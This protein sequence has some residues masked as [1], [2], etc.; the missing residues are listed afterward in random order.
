MQ[1]AAYVPEYVAVHE[2]PKHRRGEDGLGP[3][4]SDLVDPLNSDLKDYFR[5]KICETLVEKGH[6][7]VAAPDTTSMVPEAITKLLSEKHDLLTCSR[8]LA[9]A[10]YNTQSGSNNAGLLIAL[11]GRI[12]DAPA[13]AVLKLERLQGVRVVSETT[14]SGQRHFNMSHLRDLMLNE[15][16]RVFKAGVFTLGARGAVEGVVSDEQRGSRQEEVATF[17]LN[18]FLGCELRVSPKAATKAFFNTAVDWIN[19]RV[20]DPEDKTKYLFAVMAELNSEQRDLDPSEFARRSLDVNDRES[21]LHYLAA[22]DAPTTVFEKDVA[23]VKTQL[24][25]MRIDIENN[26]FVF[27]PPGQAD[28]VSFDAETVEATTTTTIQGA[29]KGFRG[30]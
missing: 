23:M 4:L 18:R 13:L 11:S 7:V 26:I 2:V 17:F 29:L 15:R 20:E 8:E 30:R 19:V 1:L 9:V 16:T 3:E 22:N 28:K 27:V 5:D 24:R 6:Q 25:G 12:G 10:L 21:F 14:S